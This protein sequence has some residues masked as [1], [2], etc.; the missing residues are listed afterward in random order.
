MDEIEKQIDK[1]RKQS[2]Q[3]TQPTKEPTCPVGQLY[4]P[5]KKTCSV[6]TKGIID[7]VSNTVAT[8]ITSKCFIATAVYGDENAPE[9]ETLREIRDNV[10]MKD[11]LGKKFVEFYYSGAGEKTAEFIK[12]DAP[13][14]IPI[15]KKELDYVVNKYNEEKNN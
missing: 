10:L 4:D 7:R 6:V 5:N 15:I 8:V 12:N 1:C 9:V 3:L 11:K 13:F 14:L 2:T